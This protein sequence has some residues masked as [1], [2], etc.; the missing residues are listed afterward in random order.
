MLEIL[1]VDEQFGI[2]V[3]PVIGDAET[4]VL[5][6]IRLGRLHF[7]KEPFGAR[8]L[9]QTS[10]RRRKSNLLIRQLLQSWVPEIAHRFRSFVVIR[11]RSSH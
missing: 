8:K 1:P 4:N 11:G 3:R 2:R 7:R 10:R 5:V 6:R 9:G